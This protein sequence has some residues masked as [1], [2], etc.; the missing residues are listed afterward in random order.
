MP[1]TDEVNAVIAYL[2]QSLDKAQTINEL[3][4]DLAK[5][6]ISNLNFE[7][8]VIYLFDKENNKLFQ[9]AAL[10]PK[11]PKAKIIAN[12]IEIPLGA[13]IVGSVALNGIAELIGDTSK[14]ARYIV[15]DR[16]R[17]SEIA[18]PIKYHDY[19]IGVI[20]SEHSQKDF[21]TKEH[22]HIL[23]VIASF[24]GNKIREIKQAESV[25][26]ESFNKSN[27]LDKLKLFTQAETEHIVLNTQVRTYKLKKTEI[28]RA[29]ADGNYCVVYTNSGLKIML[30]KTLK[31]LENELDSDQFLRPHKSHLVNI[32]YITSRIQNELHLTDNTCIQVSVRKQA[33]IKKR[34]DEM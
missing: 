27:Y 29:E 33:E 6:C 5:K 30:A 25:K 21:F 1:N 12:P 17:Y 16:R 13:G 31:N 11:N 9:S 34:L 20:D 26:E 32:R 10:G 19:V 28:I 8:C 23:T 18:V 15:D 3:V 4:W 22:L 7:D 14:D 2:A 24:A